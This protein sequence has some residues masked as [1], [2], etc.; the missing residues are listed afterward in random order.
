MGTS[1]ISVE[2]GDSIHPQDES[3]SCDSCHRCASCCRGRQKERRWWFQRSFM[4][5]VT[6]GLIWHWEGLPQNFLWAKDC[7]G[8]GD[9]SWCIR[10]I[11]GGQGSDK[12][13]HSAVQAKARL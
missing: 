7:E 10:R 9:W 12:V 1:T 2:K 11:Q 3:D 5:R 8:C 4:G 6:S 13:C